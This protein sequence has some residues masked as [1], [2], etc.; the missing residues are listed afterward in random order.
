MA[1]L[2]L[3]RLMLRIRTVFTGAIGPA[4]QG[5]RRKQKEPDRNC[6]NHRN[7]HYSTEHT[8]GRVR[9]IHINGEGTLYILQYTLTARLS[10]PFL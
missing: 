5:V 7:I 1:L 6:D 4:G 10:S 3:V 8:N 2:E 9:E